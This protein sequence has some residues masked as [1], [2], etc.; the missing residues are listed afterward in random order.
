MPL[1]L[2][3]SYNEEI[4]T[5]SLTCPCERSEAIQY[6]SPVL[7]NA[8]KQSSI[9]CPSLRTQWSNP[10]NKRIG[11]QVDRHANTRD[12]Q[13]LLN[14]LRTSFHS[15]EFAQTVCGHHFTVGNLLKPSADTISQ[16]RICSNCVR[17]PFHSGEFA[18]TVCEH[19][20]TAGNLLKPSADTISQLGICS[21]RLR[22]PFHSWEFAQTVCGDR[23][24]VGNS[25]KLSYFHPK[26]IFYSLIKKENDK[27]NKT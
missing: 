22:T 26:I 1:P 5:L 9:T 14:R 10:K 24:T 23:F 20:F 13:L 19:H 4:T 16:L 21:N 3:M 25:A 7:A 2:R 11:L 27:H 17:T 8:V 15:W 12:D 6:H 18:Q